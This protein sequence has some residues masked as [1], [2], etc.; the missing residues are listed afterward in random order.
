MARLPGKPH[1]LRRSWHAQGGPIVEGFAEDYAFTV[2]A[3][4]EL[5]QATLDNT[6]RREARALMATALDQ[7]FDEGAETVL[8]EQ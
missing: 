2:E 4:L 3:M 8:R 6:W 7:F 5:H 1:C